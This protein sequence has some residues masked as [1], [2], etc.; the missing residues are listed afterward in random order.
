[1]N[2]R[3]AYDAEE[4]AGLVAQE[5]D[6]IE[7]KSGLGQHPL[8]EA[9]VSL[10]NSEGGV[11]FIGVAND[12]SVTGR[13]LDQGVQDKIHAAALDA[14]D[15]GRYR[16]F[17]V[18][19]DSRRIVAIKVARREEGF[20]QTSDGRVLVRRG[21]RNA[22]L[23]GS[24]LARFITE[25]GLRR[26]ESTDTELRLS[27]VDEELLGELCGALSWKRS[28]AQLSDR[29]QERGLLTADNTLTIAGALFLTDP[30]ISLRSSKAI[31]DVR[32]YPGEGSD[33]D[34]REE[35]GGP[36]HH[37]VANATGSLM[38]ELGSDIVVTGLYRHE[39]PRLPEVVV[40]EA[41]ANAVAHRQYELQGTPILVEIRAQGLIVSSPGG[42]PEPVTIENMR[43]AQA[44][45]NPSVIDVLRR[46]RLAEDAG[47]G[48]DVIQDTMAEALLN[49]PEFRDLGHAVS[50]T[51]PVLGPI[52]PRERAWVSD[53]ERR[54]EIRGPDRL[55]LVH[56]ARGV[57]LANAKARQILGVGHVE[58]REILQRLRDAG[59]LTQRGARGKVTYALEER[60]APP[61]AFRMSPEQI[62]D[63]VLREAKDRPLSNSVVRELTG[64][65]RE[66]ALALLRRLVRAKR[67]S[68]RGKKRGTRYFAR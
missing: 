10:S 20:A 12:G 32:R 41:I 29:L 23:Y 22:A 48:V 64:L 65:D 39:L 50:V 17:E 36:L 37:Q 49:P 63:L 27:D 66:A 33:Y 57:V 21:G 28:D 42:L 67:L 62:E 15:V 1:M 30:T 52:T 59:L 58:A 8:Q 31:V 47:R 46:F 13:R 61:A 54:G 5:T 44:A 55:L 7:L 38:S 24:E 40:R 68:R 3:A 6:E 56:A 2:V 11:V 53:L 43:Q 18:T 34:R 25:R 45:R 51:L 26:F 4:F 9:L 19:V 35:F 16:I 14:K 60:I